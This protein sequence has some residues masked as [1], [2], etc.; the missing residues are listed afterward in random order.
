M[1]LSIWR[2]QPTGGCLAACMDRVGVARCL[3]DPQTKSPTPVPDATGAPFS[4]GADSPDAV[5]NSHLQL[6]TGTVGSLHHPHDRAKRR[7]TS[8][9][10][11]MGSNRHA[12]RP[13]AMHL[14]ALEYLLVCV[15]VC[16]RER[17]G[18]CCVC[19]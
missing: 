15:C 14:A 17:E 4:C 12:C 9:K 3:V 5:V 11:F 10:D 6:R 18:V 7:S 19:G 2:Q 1:I 13:A 16:E 8:G